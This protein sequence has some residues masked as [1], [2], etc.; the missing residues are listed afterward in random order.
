MNES[1]GAPRTRD[2]LMLGAI[3]SLAGL[4]VI[5]FVIGFLVLPWFQPGNRPKSMLE[6]IRQGL[7]MHPHHMHMAQAQPPL[8]VPTYV[9]WNEV[10]IHEAMSGDAQRGEF[11][12]MNCTGCHGDYGVTD[13]KWIPNL[14]G[15]NRLVIY[16]QLSDFRS[17]TRFSDPMSAIAQSLTPQ[18]WADVAAYFSSLQPQAAH[19]RASDEVTYDTKDVARRLIYAG[20]PQRGIAGC[21][22]CHG[23]GA[24]R[25]GAPGLITQNTAYVQQQLQDFAQGLRAND[26]NMPMRTIAAMLRPDEM[27]AV[28]AVFSNNGAGQK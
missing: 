19:A 10:T 3:A 26:M 8:R 27:H 9:V 28:A 16:K 11:I 21:A 2:T 20:D 5:L 6:A 22:T 7:G 13:Q 14:A 1:N 24:F 15:L 25:L 12:A 4:V 18:Q 23:P 17:Q